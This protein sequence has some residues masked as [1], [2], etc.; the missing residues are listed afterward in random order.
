MTGK[1][2]I[3]SKN[4]CDVLVSVKI[5]ARI[6]PRIFRLDIAL[7]GLHRS[8]IDTV[9]SKDLIV[10]LVLEKNSGISVCP[11]SYITV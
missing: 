4:E 8:L 10:K 1:I 7:L 2:L 6:L 9:N 5:T 3:H 11:K